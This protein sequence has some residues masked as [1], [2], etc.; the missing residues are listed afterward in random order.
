MLYLVYCESAH[1]CGYGQHWVVDAIDEYDADYQVQPL[2]D[3]YFFEQDEEQLVED[4]LDT[5][6][7]Y[8]TVKT[9]EEFGPEHDSWKH[10]QDPKQEQF[11]IK[12]NV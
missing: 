8:A 7:I 3:E 10:Y 4:G 12:V 6:G 2:A 1:Y 11:Y 9:I 5:E